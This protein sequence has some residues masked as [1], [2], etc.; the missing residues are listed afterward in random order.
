[1][2][3]LIVLGVSAL[4]VA[5]LLTPVCRTAAIRL[6]WVDHP[7]TIRKFHMKSTPRVGGTV[8][9]VA[10]LVAFLPLRFLPLDMARLADSHIVVR[11]LLPGAT[12]VF[13]TGL[14]DDL[15]G[16]TPWQKFSG[17]LAASLMAT[18]A[19]VEIGGIASHPLF[20]WCAIPVTVVW[21]LVC[22]NALNLIDGV[23]G[24]A[25]GVGLFATSATVIA[26]VLD[27]HTGLAVATIPLVGGL[28]GIL[29]F[30]FSPASI[31]LGDSGS[32]FIGF[33][34]G[35]YSILWNQESATILSMTA[36]IMALSIPLLD[37]GLAIIRRF[38]RRQPI[39]AADH[40]HIHHKL[41]ARG[42]TPRRVVLLVY[43]ICGL[44]AVLSLIERFAHQHFGAGMVLLYCGGAAIGVHY[45]GYA[46]FEMAR[47]IVMNGNFRRL[48]NSELRLAEFTSDLAAAATPDR[49][50]EVLQKNYSQFGFSEIRLKLGN[51]I[52]TD[53]T[54]GHHV[55]NRWTIR[56]DLPENDYV[57]LSR[58]YHA[59]A[60]PIVAR[61]TDAIGK[62]L[63]EKASQRVG[64]DAPHASGALDVERNRVSTRSEEAVQPMLL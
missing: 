30:N 34:L 60:P 53:T 3:M 62:V 35:C 57:N 15:V 47:R 2:W 12:I 1:M 10:Y 40:G 23:D 39:F 49:Y 11:M 32:L 8:V 27:G 58:E 36:P 37:T 26:A 6:G 13:L 5:F 41:L 7:D 29:W 54:N 45:L 42:L 9:Y 14:L 46:E 4:C 61:F 43:V 17:Q 31:F 64:I 38:L 59:E 22:T 21:L 33:L 24:L 50:W 51:H 48:L 16:L 20:S 28:L 18:S 55:A 63:C 52:Y 56:I 25:A 19:G 44:C